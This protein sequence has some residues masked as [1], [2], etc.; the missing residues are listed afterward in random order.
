MLHLLACR[1]L[2]DEKHRQAICS[3]LP[4]GLLPVFREQPSRR[5][6]MVSNRPG[7]TRCC[8]PSARPY[9]TPSIS[10]LQN[11]KAQ[12]HQV[13][14]QPSPPLE[15]PTEEGA[16]ARLATAEGD[17]HECR[18][19]RSR[20]EHRCRN[21]MKR[22]QDPWPPRERVGQHKKGDQGVTFQERH[23]GFSL[24]SAVAREC[25]GLPLPKRDESSLQTT[26]TGSATGVVTCLEARERR[27][28]PVAITTRSATTLA[29][30]A[31]NT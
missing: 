17:H 9:P 22:R 30:T 31:I 8:L 29:T 5:S 26:A 4:R 28:G 14:L 27:A 7:E 6:S 19:E 2:L 10:R 24:P 16:H 3:F 11:R 12:R 23:D 1:C 13:P 25:N 21:Q 18:N 20:S 15:Q